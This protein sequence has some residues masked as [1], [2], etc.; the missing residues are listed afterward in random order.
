MGSGRKGC[1]YE[2][3]VESPSDVLHCYGCDLAYHC[4]EGEGHHGCYTDA[5]GAGAGIEDLGGY[6][7]G[8][9]TVG[10]GEAEVV[11]P[12]CYY[13][14]PFCSEV[15]GYTWW[16]FGEERSSDDEGYAVHQVA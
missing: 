6:N 9:G 7:P 5:L 14:T 16:E 3:D 2:K 10:A 11:D 1:A 4:V 15:L 13:E 12:G 8:Q